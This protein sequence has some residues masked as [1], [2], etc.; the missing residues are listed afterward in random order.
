M[1]KPNID[2]NK[3]EAVIRAIHDHFEDE[4]DLDDRIDQAEALPKSDWDTKIY[5]RN[6][7]GY[8][9]LTTV[10]NAATEYRFRRAWAEIEE[11]LSNEEIDE[12]VRWAK[13]QAPE[14]NLRPELL[15]RPNHK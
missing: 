15:E 1:V 4:L 9:Q 5:A 2:S 12:L 6:A 10:S 7:V 11:L 8:S 13:S 3:L 14:L